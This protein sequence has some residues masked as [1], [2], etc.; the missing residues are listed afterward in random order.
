MRIAV[1]SG[2]ILLG[3]VLLGGSG[4]Q[5]F[6]GPVGFVTVFVG[7]YIIGGL[8]WVVAPFYWTARLLELI[9]RMIS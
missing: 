4:S 2:V 3:L 8:R 1:A 6:L 7:L 5:S 9:F